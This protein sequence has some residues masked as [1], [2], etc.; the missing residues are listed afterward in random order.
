[1]A[2]IALQRITGCK[3]AP[4]NFGATV[5]P[6]LSAQ[7]KASAH[8]K[9]VGETNFHLDTH[10]APPFHQNVLEDNSVLTKVALAKI[11]YQSEV[12]ASLIAMVQRSFF[13]SGIN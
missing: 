13:R 11:Y 4:F 7:T 5:T 9:V 8:Q 2:V 1:M 10:K 12:H 3:P 6:S